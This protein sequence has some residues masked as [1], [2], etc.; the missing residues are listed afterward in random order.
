MLSAD[1]TSAIVDGAASAQLR[2]AALGLGDGVDLSRCDDHQLVELLGAA[3][4]Q[5]RLATGAAAAPQLLRL[6]TA[7]PP[8]AAPPPPAAAPRAAAAAAPPAA[9]STFGSQ[10]DVAAMVAVLQQAARDG[11]PLCEECEA[12]AAGGAPR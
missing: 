2:L 5:G 10:L 1:F 8:A 9:D 11:T 4:S 6:P 7:A 3:V 12:A